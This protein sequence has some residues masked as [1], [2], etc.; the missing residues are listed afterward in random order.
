M[1]RGALIT[2]IALSL[3]ACGGGSHQSP[4]TQTATTGTTT[5][6]AAIP[7]AEKQHQ[8]SNAKA[9]A[10]L[11][12]A[13]RTALLAN[14]A[15]A[16]H[17]LW[18][19]RVPNSATRSTR[20]PALAG[21][22]DSARGRQT[23]GVRVRMVHD[24]YRIASIDLDHSLARATAVARSIQTVLPSHLNGR[25]IG[26]SVRLNERARILLRRLGTSDSF[27]VWSITLLK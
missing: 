20:G 21:M 24:D 10:T 6:T 23:R 13:V 15:L 2:A 25:P 22:R 3:A 8:G 19:N 9:R 17:V 7:T 4:T 26:R 11:R 27:V 12:E 18:T 16:I 1:K 14:H 5:S